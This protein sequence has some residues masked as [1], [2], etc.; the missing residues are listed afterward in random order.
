MKDSVSDCSEDFYKRSWIERKRNRKEKSEK[1][2]RKKKKE[3]K[4]RK[5]NKYL[6]VL[7]L[8]VIF[9]KLDIMEFFDESRD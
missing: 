8:Q 3:K 6:P 5:S 9:I 2:T 1:I 7:S 4:E